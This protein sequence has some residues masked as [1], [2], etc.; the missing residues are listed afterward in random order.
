MGGIPPTPRYAL[1]NLREAGRELV[2]G[3][4]DLVPLLQ[5]IVLGAT[6]CASLGPQSAFV[7]RQ[8]IHGDAAFGVAMVCTF[9]DFLLIAAAAAGADAISRSL[10]HAAS[11]GA[12]GGAI[13]ASAFGCF[14]LAGALRHRPAVVQAPAVG[15]MHVQAIVVALALSLLNPQVYL[16]MIVLVGG[17][18]LSFPPAERALFAVGV[19]IVSPLWFFGLVIGGRRLSRLFARPQA[20]AALDLA[21]GLAMLTLAAAIVVGELA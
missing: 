11:I 10:P 20:L 1:K 2:T 19:A 21:T 18:A 13:I 6:I 15:A 12:W 3:G 17:M 8:G 9:A 4:S 5:G 7:L 14:A 16:E